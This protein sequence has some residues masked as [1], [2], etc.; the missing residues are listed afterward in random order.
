VSCSCFAYFACS[1]D[2]VCCCIYCCHRLSRLCSLELTIEGACSSLAL[3]VVLSSINTQLPQLRSLALTSNHSWAGAQA[4]WEQLGEAT[5]LTQLGVHF[6]RTVGV[7]AHVKNLAPL[8]SLTGLQSLTFQLVNKGEQLWLDGVDPADAGFLCHL[9]ALT[10][11]QGD[12]L[13]TAGM[14]QNISSCTALQ[15]LSLRAGFFVRPSSSDWQVLGNLSHLTKLHVSG[16]MLG[17]QGLPPFYSAL[18]CLTN[19]QDIRVSPKLGHCTWAAVPALASLT[20]LTCVYGDWQAGQHGLDGEGVCEH[21]VRWFEASNSVPFSAFPNVELV[22]LAGALDTASWEALGS[23]CPKVRDIFMHPDLSGRPAWPC[24]LPAV[25]AAERVSALKGFAQLTS[26]TR[27]SFNISHKLQVVAL[28]RCDAAGAS[29]EAAR[30]SGV[31]SN[32][33][34][35][36]GCLLPL[37]K[38]TTVK[39]AKIASRARLTSKHDCQVLLAALVCI[40]R[41]SLTV[42]A[43]D[44]AMVKEAVQESRAIGLGVPVHVHGKVFVA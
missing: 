44:V 30:A 6:D 29:P 25:T 3:G 26:L 16:S 14:L 36:W 31:G 13:L 2:V 41:V 22:G 34:L 24:F 19:L 27:L 17:D 42:N 18:E 8:S 32:P 7:G 15:S 28:C 20:R 10:P 39:L 9:T 35:D 12:F 5:Q 37:G 38:L 23:W 4:V 43:A 11:L 40:H 1:N 33:G 21:V